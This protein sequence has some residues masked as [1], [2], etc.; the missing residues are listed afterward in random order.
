MNSSA[1]ASVCV[2]LCR[3]PQRVYMARL[4]RCVHMIIVYAVH[5]YTYGMGT[6][7]YMRTHLWWKV[8]PF[9]P[10]NTLAKNISVASRCERCI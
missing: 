8:K 5:T 2:C 7:A 6:R 9:A 1:C 10:V 3:Q 4:S